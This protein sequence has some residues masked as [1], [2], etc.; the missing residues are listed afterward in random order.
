MSSLFRLNIFAYVLRVEES[1][2]SFFWL[3]NANFE[4]IARQT[5]PK[6]RKWIH[7]GAVHDH[8][9]QVSIVLYKLESCVLQLRHGVLIGQA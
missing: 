4:I 9:K 7:H 2:L 3:R 1:Y 8:P 6:E 5:G